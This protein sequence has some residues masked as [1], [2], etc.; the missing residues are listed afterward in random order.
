MS[1]DVEKQ[2]LHVPKSQGGEFILEAV[3]DTNIKTT[4]THI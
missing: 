3:P 4:N 1:E 2:L